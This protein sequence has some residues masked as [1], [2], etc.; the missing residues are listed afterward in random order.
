MSKVGVLGIDF[1]T[2]NT[3]AAWVDRKGQLHLVPVSEKS[4]CMP[5]VVWYRSRD[6][7]VVG[8]TA[9]QQIVDDPLNTVWGIKRFI[10]RRYKSSFVQ[11]NHERMSCEMCELPTGSCGVKIHGQVIPATEVVCHIIQRILE[12]AN[13]AAG[14]E[15]GECVLTAPAHFGYAAR[16][17][18]RTAAEMAGLEVRGIINE[19]TAAALYCAKRRGIEQTILIYDLGGG[20]FDLSLCAIRGQLVTVLGT[21][22]DAFLGGNDFDAQIAQ[23]LA[24][25]FEAEHKV[26]LRSNK[27]VMQ[28]LT[29]A[30]E[31]AKIALAQQEEVQ[32]HA[33]FVA[34]RDGQPVDF[35]YTLTRDA[36]ETMTSNLIE[37]TLGLC[38]DL[39]HDVGMTPQQV[40]ELVFVGGQTRMLA[41]Q[42]RLAAA[43]R[44]DPGRNMNPE[45]GVAVGAAILGRGLDLP[46]G[47]ELADVVSLPINAMLPGGDTREVIPQNTGVPAVRRTVFERK[48]PPGLPMVIA[49]VES[50][51]ARSVDREMLGTLRIEPGWLDQHA[52]QLELELRI[53]QDYDLTASIVAA[54]GNR[55][56][57]EVTAPKL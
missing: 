37:G 38:E 3:N 49:L 34:Q 44:T 13:A 8:A 27:V 5:S 12:L 52:G 28:R 11:R 53:G 48:T 16:R 22:G 23:R 18:L 39:L 26:E 36:L 10:G 54:D 2:T 6:K 41:L 17:A 15:F 33:P 45:M 46:G 14:A 42:R 57:L 24:S 4:Y 29:F 9:R 50:S 7:Y 1:G 43:F 25:R 19:P 56:A 47:P 55:L 20:T 30:A 32:L 21:G 35:D 31:N 40:D 51:D